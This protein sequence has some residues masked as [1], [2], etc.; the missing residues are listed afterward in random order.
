MPDELDLITQWGLVV[1]GFTASMRA[2]DH[3]TQ[4]R[5][6]L[7]AAWFEVLLRLRRT[8]GATLPTTQLAADVSFSSGGFTKLA[9]RLEGHGL[10]ARQACPTDRR[11][12]WITLTDEGAAVIDAAIVSHEAFLRSHVVDV[13]GPERLAA[14]GDAMRALR[15]HHQ[16]PPPD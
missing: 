11:V 13:I 7:P 16:G 8:P 2:M 14:L 15:D 5:H 6:D 1:E 10:V 4:S 12:T 9:D 3:D